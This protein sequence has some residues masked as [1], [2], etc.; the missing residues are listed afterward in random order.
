LGI[1]NGANTAFMTTPFSIANVLVAPDM[2]VSLSRSAGLGAIGPNEESHP[3]ENVAR[4]LLL[5]SFGSRSFLCRFPIKHRQSATWELMP[6][7]GHV[8]RKSMVNSG[9]TPIPC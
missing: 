6:A 5:I 8:A 9:A 4:F 1:V 3:K 7:V 2:V